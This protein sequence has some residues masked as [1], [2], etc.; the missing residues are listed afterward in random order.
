MR[1]IIG[2]VHGMLEPLEQLLSQVARRDKR[3]SLY[4]CGD[5]CDRGPDTRKVVDLLMGLSDASFVRGNHDD[6]M[7]LCCNGTSLGIGP[8]MGGPAD[9]ETLVE[10]FNL[11]RFEGLA[12][13]MVSYDI[14]PAGWTRQEPGELIADTIRRLFRDVPASHKQFFRELPAVAEAEDFF[15]CHATWPADQLDEEGR[16]NGMVAGDP[17]LRHDVLWG[18]YTGNQIKSKKVW[19]RPGYFG[20]T[21]TDNYLS[22]PGLLEAPGAIIRGEKATLLDTAAFSPTGRLTAYC[23]DSGEVV[24]VGWMVK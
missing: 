12:E 24:Q 10:V 6:V 3:A 17:Y 8:A 23:H 18:R 11:F 7:D 13:T 4:F 19:K 15:V 22:L 16:M 21:P 5:Y 14:D 2:D 1:W 9:D 20:H